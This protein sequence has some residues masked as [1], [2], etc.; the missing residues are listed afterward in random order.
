MKNA[1][2][3]VPLLIFVSAAFP[4]P[5]ENP[6][7]KVEKTALRVEISA[8]GHFEPTAARS[9]I[10]RPEGW[11]GR[12]VVEFAVEPGTVVAEGDVV[13]RFDPRAIREAID[14]ARFNLLHAEAE[15][16]MQGRRSRL[17][18]DAATRDLR[19][20]R[21]DLEN[22]ERRLTDWI[23]YDKPRDVKRS[24][25]DRKSQDQSLSNAEEELR[26]LEKMYA[27]DELVDD[28]EE[29]VLERSRFNLERRR[30][31]REWWIEARKRTEEV[32]Q[33]RWLEQTQFDLSLKVASFDK[34]NQ[35][36][37]MSTASRKI[38]AARADRAWGKKKRD[39]ER[40]EHVLAT[41]EIRA[42]VSG[43][44]LH[45]PLTGATARVFKPGNAV[46]AGD[47][48][49]SIATP[50][51]LIA[52]LSVPARETLRLEVGTPVRLKPEAAG[53]EPIETE[54][55]YVS[56]LPKGGNF[57][58]RCRLPD[59]TPAGLL[60]TAVT[61]KIL[62]DEA[63]DVLTLPAAAVFRS[64]DR[65]FCL[66][67]EGLVPVTIGREADGRVEILGGLA[68]GDVVLPAPPELKK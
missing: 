9:V 31:L 20:K 44:L 58:V 2:V 19:R 29:I 43:V 64:G 28:T 21:R 47:A 59:T 23:E 33:V 13:L 27:E 40:L 60:G 6:E 57:V 51:D 46:N 38:A 34:A 68:E 12:Y 16:E 32:T 1:L 61:A 17:T 14:D 67:A 22:A 39:L 4:A 65:A 37:E 36:Y 11:R 10:P 54:V 5:E 50:G 3:C 62:I 8:K 15:Y 24:I 45:G 42:P 48:V 30:R 53:A 56:P 41:M 66:T 18:A 25:L 55:T 63:K 35:E 49:I 26:Q 7:L 52:V